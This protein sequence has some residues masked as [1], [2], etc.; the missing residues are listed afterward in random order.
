VK[1]AS[2]ARWFSFGGLGH[3]PGD[4]ERCPNRARGYRASQPVTD[5]IT[6]L[7]PTCTHIGC[8]R[9]A[10]RCDLDHA[11]NYTDGGPT[12]VC[13]LRPSCRFHHRLKTHGG[14]AARFTT[15]TEPCAPGT[16]A[17]RSRH[18][19]IAHVPPAEL[20]GSNAWTPPTQP[21]TATPASDTDDPTGTDDVTGI[22]ADTGT[23]TDDA[24]DTHKDVDDPC[25]PYEAT[26]AERRQ[27]RENTWHRELN[28]INGAQ[29]HSPAPPTS[30]PVPTS[31][32][33]PMEDGWEPPF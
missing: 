29:H 27:L 20:P 13:N 33:A 7:H 1:S 11:I 16:V 2:T 18:G 23:G 8:S 17:L 19:Q 9:P 26:T 22:D 10:P 25:C 3:G 14:W 12:C 32:S 5:E 24:T 30:A 21:S 28:R 6:T 31:A 4:Q 15:G